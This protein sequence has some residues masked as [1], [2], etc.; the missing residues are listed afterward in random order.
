MP[1]GKFFIITNFM[2]IFD[3]ELDLKFAEKLHQIGKD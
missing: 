1:I 3:C 2:L